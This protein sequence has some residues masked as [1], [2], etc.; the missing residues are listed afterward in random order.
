[1]CPPSIA[2]TVVLRSAE[3]QPRP[4]PQVYTALPVEAG[5][6]TT[7]ADGVNELVGGVVDRV[8]GYTAI[9]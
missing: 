9:S 2:A 6:P 8:I 5:H 1:M 3:R 4:I 7:P